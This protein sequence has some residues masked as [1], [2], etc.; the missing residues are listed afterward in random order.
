MVNGASAVLSLRSWRVTWPSPTRTPTGLSE[1]NWGIPPGGVVTRALAA[2]I[3]QRDALYYIMTG[4]RFDGR[5]AEQLRLVNEALPTERLRERTREVALKLAATNR[6]VL[7]AA[8][9]GY[10]VGGDMPWEQAEDYLYAKLEQSQL[11]DRAR[12]RAKGLEQFLDDKSYRPGLE[13]FDRPS[14]RVLRRK[15]QACSITVWALAGASC[16]HD[17]EQDRRSISRPQPQLRRTRRPGHPCGGWLR[18]LGVRFGDRGL[19]GAER[20]EYLVFVRRRNA[21]RFGS[22]RRL[23]RRID[24]VLADSG[25]SVA[26]HR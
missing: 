23:A 17:A 1:I 9:M 3:S 21:R 19:S 6:V 18:R 7:H 13:S 15:E 14:E 12:S 25:A 5:K 4:E 8:K 26:V 22:K 24:Y 20:P 16:P 2:T 10:K 11:L